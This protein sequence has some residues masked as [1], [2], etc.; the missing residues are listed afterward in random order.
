MLPEEIFPSMPMYRARLRFRLLKKLNIEANNY[1]FLVAGREV[2][3]SAPTPD[4]NIRESDWLVMNV[5]GFASEDEAREF[6]NSLRSA[7]ELSSVAT[8]LGVDA[9]RDLPTSAL[10]HGIKKHL[11]KESGT[12]IRDNIH[13]LDVFEDNPRV[14]IFSINA[15]ATIH[16][17]HD[18]FLA[19]AVELHGL[20]S[21]LSDNAKD[22]ILLL[23]YALM[24]PEPVAQIV[25]S[26]SAVEMLGQTENWTVTQKNLLLWLAKVA[27]SC[28]KGSEQERQEVTDAIA[29]SLHRLTL[30]Q[31]VMRILERLNLTHLKKEWDKLYEERSTLVHGLAPQPGVDY[32]DLAN[33]AVSLCG[34]IL[35]KAIAAELPIADK[36]S[37]SYYQAQTK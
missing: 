34:Y 18:P 1:P 36:Y 7:I 10:F 2:I 6:G 3:L 12:I 9:G 4:S 22:V 29:K 14:V 24:R 17:N 13:G 19:F 23:N 8:R 26:I 27:E 16:A 32:S 33:R 30:R 35:M 15:T 11:E 21:G 28:D 25:F 31:G 5:K 20:D 37:S